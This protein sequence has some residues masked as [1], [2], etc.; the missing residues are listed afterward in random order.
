MQIML[1][2]LLLIAIIVFLIYKINNQF[3]VKEF[4]LLL[5]VIVVSILVTVMIIRNSKGKVPQLFKEKYEKEKKVSILELSFERLNNKITSSNIN[6]I[7]NFDY[8]IKKD[9]QEFVCTAKAV[10]IK[11]IEDAYIFENFDNLKEE[12]KK[13]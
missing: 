2:S 3:G 4:L 5:I 7:Y 1:F 10:K 9:D 11:R 13:K 6:F 8:I 12:C